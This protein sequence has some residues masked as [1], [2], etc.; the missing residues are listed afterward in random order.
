MAIPLARLSL[1][2]KACESS[3]DRSTSLEL[4]WDARLVEE[5]HTQ[6]SELAS[7]E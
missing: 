3:I 7:G 6:L 4:I 2:R 1:P 5:G